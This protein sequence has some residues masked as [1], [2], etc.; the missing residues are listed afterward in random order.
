MTDNQEFHRDETINLLS[1]ALRRG[2]AS[3]GNVPSLL[4]KV[5]KEDMWQHRVVPATGETEDFATFKEFVETPP[6]LGLGATIKLIKRICGE[7]TETLD[8]IDRV[9]QRLPGA[10]KGNKNASNSETNIDIINNC[11]N[12]IP[13]GTSREN[14]L[15]KLRKDRPDLH[16]EVIA[17]EKSPHAAMVEAGFRKKSLTIPIDPEPAARSLVKN[18]SREQLAVLLEVILKELH[19]DDLPF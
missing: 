15:R 2:D 7:D 16:K 13:D 6:L 4:K 18:F 11:S 5:L 9:E 3:L 8:L 1:Q 12:E 10:P 17:G 14:A 19:K